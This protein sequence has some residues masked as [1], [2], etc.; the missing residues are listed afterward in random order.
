[1]IEVLGCKTL[2]WVSNKN[3]AWFGRSF[4]MV[5]IGGV[6]KISTETQ[7]SELVLMNQMSKEELA[8]VI[9]ELIR[10]NEEVRMAIINLACTSPY[11]KTQM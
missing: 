11:I 6:I 9:S 3:T 1:M 10:K 4:R 2:L 5:Q 7:Q 8:K